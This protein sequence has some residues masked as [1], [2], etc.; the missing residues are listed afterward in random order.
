MSLFF[1]NWRVLS[2]KALSNADIHE[3]E[4]DM[5]IEN[6][7]SQLKDNFYEYIDNKEVAGDSSST[8]KLYDTI[9][10]KMVREGNRTAVL[11]EF[12]SYSLAAMQFSGFFFLTIELLK[13][14]PCITKTIPITA[15]VYLAD[16][17]TMVLDTSLTAGYFKEVLKR[18]MILVVLTYFKLLTSD[19]V[20]L[21]Q[22]DSS[23]LYK[24][25]Y[26][27]L[28]EHAGY[29]L[30]LAPATTTFMGLFFCGVLAT[31]WDWGYTLDFY[32]FAVT[33]MQTAQA[34]VAV[35]KSKA[36]WQYRELLANNRQ[37][38]YEW[39]SNLKMAKSSRLKRKFQEKLLA[40]RDLKVK[41][42]GS[43]YLYA[44]VM[45]ILINHCDVLLPV[46]LVGWVLLGNWSLLISG[47]AVDAGVSR[48]ALY[49]RKEYLIT[50]ICA[51]HYYMSKTQHVLCQVDL[52]MRKK[53]ATKFYDQLFEVNH[54]TTRSLTQDKNM[55]LGELQIQ[56]CDVLVRDQYSDH[57]SEK[58]LLS[59]ELAQSG[60]GKNLLPEN[61]TLGQPREDAGVPV[62]LK[63]IQGLTL[64]VSTGERICIMAND[65]KAAVEG[66]FRAIIGEAII[67]RGSLRC[68]GKISCFN[69]ELMPFLA[70]S[71]V[72][73]NILFGENYN[74]DRYEQVLRA[75]RARFDL[76][77]G[78]D[79]YQ[80]GVKGSNMKSDDRF[81]IL[82]AR[83]LYR[84]THIYVAE[85]LFMGGNLTLV[86]PIAHSIFFEFLQNKTIIFTAKD[87]RIVQIASQ[88]VS[89]ESNRFAQI[90]RHVPRMEAINEKSGGL[91]YT[92]HGPT[93]NTIFIQNQSFDEDL[94]VRRKLDMQKK[95]VEKAVAG[96]NIFEKIAYGIYLTN[97]RRQEGISIEE[98]APSKVASMR[99]K[100]V[101]SK[102]RKTL[103]RV[104]AQVFALS[105]I[106]SLVSFTQEHLQIN[107]IF[108]PGT[109]KVSIT[110]G[111]AMAIVALF[112][113]RLMLAAVQVV[114]FQR[115]FLRSIREIST[116]IIERI[117]ES[118]F[119]TI[120]KKNPLSIL[121]VIND[122]LPTVEVQ[123]AISMFHLCQG[124][125]QII[126]SMM[127][128]IWLGSAVFPLILIGLFLTCV[129]S[130]L[131]R[132]LPSYSTAASF[133]QFNQTKSD[134]FCFH[135]MPL[136][137]GHRIS[138]SLS[139]L[140][141]K[142][143]LI[144]DTLA[145]SL[146]FVKLDYRMFI[147][148]IL[149]FVLACFIFFTILTTI[150]AIGN[151]SLNLLNVQEH[152]ILWV[153]PIIFRLISH[154]ESFVSIVVDQLREIPH[155]YK[156]LLF[157]DQGDKAKE[158]YDFRYTPPPPNF[159][160]PLVFKNVSLTL[161]YKPV[162]KKINFKVKAMQRVGVL[163]L[164][165]CGRSSLFDLI[166][167]ARQ[168]D[169]RDSTIDIFGIPLEFLV[170][171]EAR[172][173]IYLL[174]KEPLLLEGTI[175]DNLDPYAQFSDFEVES[176]LMQ[177]GIN[178]IL[179]RNHLK[180]HARIR[181]K[182]LAKFK[183]LLNS[184]P[185]FDLAVLSHRQAAKFRPRS[186]TVVQNQVLPLDSLGKV[187]MYYQEN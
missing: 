2:K 114:A 6:I 143:L 130:I 187:E 176:V 140:N 150:G 145:R 141:T 22:T 178:Q 159:A 32:L 116:A 54:L 53:M 71:T 119:A 26:W 160:K 173:Q 162:L 98:V 163:G 61:I 39:I 3:F 58:V 131:M 44:G 81:K 73:D 110:W 182:D 16:I 4:P 60:M 47:G 149:R 96:S 77:N 69:R 33:V 17:L 75:V 49:L 132:L 104:L 63:V 70:G 113:I 14:K 174:G 36:T 109:S 9:I 164:E 59:E 94:A 25:F 40:I 19:L 91:L 142:F 100:I 79:F 181:P 185:A 8:F 86:E 11:K 169:H 124:A 90:T 74:S 35:Y 27:N 80:V 172:N 175:K 186:L 151:H 126:V 62:Y 168:R 50:C 154:V 88:R 108:E 161:G 15:A 57:K 41:V 46:V 52:C 128:L 136:I 68:N 183:D 103:V 12:L 148:K 31:F 66:F 137:V 64:K 13:E 170:A 55:G 134:E 177:L 76:Y 1:K 147:Q 45:S 112:V 121:G 38:L 78:R 10:K 158:D 179:E 167:G 117:L 129:I 83:F 20:Y 84:D 34:V 37:V 87:L 111:F 7:Y 122:Q 165:G 153:I 89:F 5:Q 144:S 65:N 48:L 146:K 120:S 107:H 23:L 30:P 21:Q 93:R 184:K 105:F 157:I 156:L 115:L 28:D 56:D 118:D 102:Y 43:F 125:S 127:T 82:L 155:F 92:S 95:T 135:L 99:Q 97:K 171:E 67:A 166:L 123:M 106:T 139:K 72:R 18:R 85:D 51:Y 138:G 24:A 180:N 101:G 152:Y 29:T 42:L 133:A